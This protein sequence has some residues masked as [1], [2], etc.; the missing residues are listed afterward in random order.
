[1]NCRGGRGFR[2]QQTPKRCFND[3]LVLGKKGRLGHL[4]GGDKQWR[5]FGAGLTA[6][7]NRLHLSR[8]AQLEF[9]HRPFSAEFSRPLR[10]V[11]SLRRATDPSIQAVSQLLPVA[12]AISRTR[13]CAAAQ[14]LYWAQDSSR[15]I[16]GMRV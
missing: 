5:K 6:I 8:K 1:M 16:S 13:L 7:V 11:S 3:G 2:R 9:C 12:S 4:C 10:K 14:A 15:V